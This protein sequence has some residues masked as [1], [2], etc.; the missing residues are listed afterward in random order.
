MP[1]SGGSGGLTPYEQNGP[2][3]YGTPEME[4]LPKYY[5]GS[6]QTPGEPL[7]LPIRIR[8]SPAPR[9]VRRD[10]T[11]SLSQSVT[12]DPMVLRPRKQFA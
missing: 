12:F 10:L 1:S 7:R 3:K 5:G 8:T 9:R 4:N 11:T 6:T 2:S